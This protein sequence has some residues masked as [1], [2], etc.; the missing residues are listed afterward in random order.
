MRALRG[1]WQVWELLGSAR[2]LTRQ[3]RQFQWSAA[4]RA[5]LFL[6]AEYAKIDLMRHE[7]DA[8]HAQL[9]LRAARGWLL[10]TDQ[11]DAGV[12]IVLKRKPLI[13]SIGGAGIRI[14][15]PPGMHV[16][17]KL[18]RCE[19]CLH[20]VSQALELAPEAEAGSV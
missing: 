13:G 11:D 14:S 2:D 12:Y 6:D 16:S 9:K 19:L 8:I 7:G 17:L 1:L 4:E 18:K 10:A 5:S 3:T 15:V 20:D